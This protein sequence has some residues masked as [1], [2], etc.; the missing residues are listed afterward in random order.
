MNAAA[1][2][3]EEPASALVPD[4]PQLVAAEPLVPAEGPVLDPNQAASERS[5]P[6]P[7]T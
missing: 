5:A 1:N 2:G 6:P 3:E 4:R 7:A